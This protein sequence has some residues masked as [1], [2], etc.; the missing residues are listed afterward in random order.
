VVNFLLDTHKVPE[1]LVVSLEASLDNL[2]SLGDSLDTEVNLEGTLANLVS[3]R[4]VS[5]VNSQEANL[6]SSPEV[7]QE[8]TLEANQ[9][10]SLE[11]LGPDSPEALDNPALIQ[12]SLVDSPVNQEDSPEDNPDSQDSLV[13]SQVVLHLVLM[14]SLEVSLVDNPVLQV[15][16]EDTVLVSQ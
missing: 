8:H 12:V 13:D 11:D 3:S 16:Q 9:G 1:P 7:S 5:L 15:N 2:D 14:V 10:N 4:G 6:V